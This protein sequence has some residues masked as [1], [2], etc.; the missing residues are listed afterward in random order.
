MEEIYNKELLLDYLEKHKMSAKTLCK[1]CNI[2]QDTVLKIM[3]NSL[4]MDL[5]DIVKLL[6]FTE[7]SFNDFL[8]D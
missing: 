8:K 6:N 3:N 7:I 5:V 4:D 2:P 1:L